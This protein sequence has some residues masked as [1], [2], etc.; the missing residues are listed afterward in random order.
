ME[1]LRDHSEDLPK[2]F[3]TEVLKPG[4]LCKHLPEF[5]SANIQEVDGLVS[6]GSFEIVDESD[7][8]KDAN[9]LGGRFIC[10][11]KNYE[12]DSET[13]K[14]RYVVQVH[15][16]KENP[17]I[18]HSIT[19]LRQSSVKIIVSTC[20]VRKFRIFYHGVTQAYLQSDE[21]VPRKI[22][23]RPNKND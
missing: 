7:V 5:C 2:L 16:D 19:T 4:D 23:F 3:V 12:T 6:R 17:F 22:Y 9:I 18:V 1:R 10:S 14:D 11:I 20:A 21:K 13:E 8:P 15:R